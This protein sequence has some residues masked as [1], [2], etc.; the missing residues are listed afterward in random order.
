VGRCALDGWGEQLGVGWVAGV[1]VVVEDEPVG[2]VGDLGLVAELDRFAEPALDLT[3]GRASGSCRDTSRDEPGGVS[4]GR[5]VRG[6]IDDPGG[7]PHEGFEVVDRTGKP[8]P[9]GRA[10]TS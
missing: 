5:R 8:S 4:P 3:I 6:L 10:L 1:H 9:C 7:A 2:V